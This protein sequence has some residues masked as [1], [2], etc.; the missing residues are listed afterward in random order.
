MEVAGPFFFGMIG[1]IIIGMVDLVFSLIDMFIN[2][3]IPFLI[4]MKILIYKIPAI[5]VLFYP[6]A[7]LFSTLIVLIR[8]AKDSEV[9]VLRA[10]GFS[11]GRIVAPIIIAGFLAFLLSYWTNEKLVP[12]A[13]NISD[14]IAQQLQ[15]TSKKG[16]IITKIAFGS[17]GHKARLKPG[18]IIFA[19]AQKPVNSMEDFQ[20]IAP[21]YEKGDVLVHTSR[22]YVVIFDDKK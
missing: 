7:V 3:G 1:F 15:L 20:K 2:N 5:M 10:G 21:K 4:V 6:M 18:D 8:I 12:W 22:G 16:V 13:N 14:E 17:Q 11:L 9:T 19:I